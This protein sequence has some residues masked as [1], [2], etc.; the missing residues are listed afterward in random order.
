MRAV[1][2]LLMPL[3]AL[4]TG[5]RAAPERAV[6]LDIEGPMGPATADYFERA[7]SD[8]VEHDASFVVVRLDTPGGLDES[9]RT[10]VQDVL[11]AP[12]PIVCYVAPSG[13]RAASAGTFL[14]YACHV[15]AMAPGTT[16]GAATPV[17]LQGGAPS[18]GEEVEA[19]SALERKVLEDAVAYI[20]GLA[21]LRGRNAE[22]AEKAVREGASLPAAEARERGVI[23]LIA[24]SPQ[25]L[26]AALDGWPVTVDDERVRL[27]TTDIEV[28][29]VTP[30]WR[31]RFLS[32]VTNPNIALLL[33]LL[34]FYGILFELSSPGFILPGVLGAVFLAIGLYGLQVLPLNYIGLG[35]LLL[36]LALMIAEAFVPSF[37]A[38][39]VGGIVAFLVGAIFLVDTEVPAFQVSKPVIAVLGIVS[40]GF[41]F[42]VMRMV[43]KARRQRAVSGSEALVGSR[44]R[45]LDGWQGREG[46]VRVH[47]E[48]WRATSE[49]PMAAGDQVEVVAVD[50]LTLRVRP[51]SA[52]EERT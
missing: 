27:E 44:A 38:L 31:T 26:F 50:D 5:V 1:L 32:V 3:L 15:A 7:L 2:A 52:K 46:A 4:S 49:A 22:W 36:G 34:G 6:W 10:M 48:R 19:S 16:L 47:G 23:D 29:E 40:A 39:G 45:V 18:G 13:A 28:V 11:G 20:R 14:L 43:V 25:A 8:A 41:F 12:L 30:D 33:M 21:E 42:I 37:G 17:Q 9:M 51:V 24:R 35:L